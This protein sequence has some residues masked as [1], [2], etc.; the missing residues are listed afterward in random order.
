MGAK[1]LSFADMAREYFFDSREAEAQFSQEKNALKAAERY[2]VVV[3]VTVRSNTG[4]M[5]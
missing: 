5:Q 2:L 3:A 1:G 4:R